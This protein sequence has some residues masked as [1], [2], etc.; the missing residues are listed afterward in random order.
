MSS[1]SD[2]APGIDPP[3]TQGNEGSAAEGSGHYVLS[4]PLLVRSHRRRAADRSPPLSA[5]ADMES[6]SAAR[7]RPHARGYASS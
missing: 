7:A 2:I 3:I 4:A 1:D 5:V 6:D